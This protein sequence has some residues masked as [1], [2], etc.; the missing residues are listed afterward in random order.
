MAIIINHNL[1]ALNA[2]RNLQS[3][4]RSL[5]S[6]VRRLSSGLRIGTAADDPA[7]LA[8]S[9]L[10]RSDI[11]AL[12]Q[13]V[14]NAND[15]ISMIQVAD[16]ALQVIDEKL[17]R[18]RELAEQ[19][20]TGTYNSDQRLMLHS[21]FI[22]MRSE[23]ERIAQETE[24]NDIKLLNTNDDVKIHFGPQN[25]S[26]EDYYYVNRQ[27]ATIDQNGLG[28]HYVDNA[29]IQ[30][31]DE[32]FSNGEIKGGQTTPPA[33]YVLIPKGAT[34]VDIHISGLFVLDA[35]MQLFTR[36]GAHLA[37][38]F[39]D[40]GVADAAEANTTIVTEQNG[41]AADATYD[42]SQVNGT[43]SDVPVYNGTA[44]YNQ[45]TAGGMTIGYSGEDTAIPTRNDY[46]HIEEATE[47]LIFVVTKA[48]IALGSYSAEV[49]WGS[50]PTSQSVSLST[51]QGA[52]QALGALRD[53]IVT[54]DNIRADLGATQNRLQNTVSNLQIQA[55]NLQ[56]AESRIRD[57]D[58]AVEMTEF[59]RGQILTQASTAMLAQANS[60]PRMA[61][62]LL[63]G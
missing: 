47:D 58:V 18:M 6:S 23:I 19:A 42:G 50:M 27:M 30:R 32:L 28:L 46:L 61:L 44:P 21:E 4:F 33:T 56:A 57:T 24:F 5:S 16:G 60:L 35:T 15:A 37:G 11:S 26:S 10:M 39:S 3:G 43:G 2:S 7:G 54:K 40:L 38:K 41:F 62:Q 45:F 1:M 63:G 29:Y 9:E 36:D 49:S 12:K 8:V 53:A 59:V 34:D 25:D 52:Q 48:A 51:Q 13:G 31:I 17:I 22:A 20:A 55:E 14:R